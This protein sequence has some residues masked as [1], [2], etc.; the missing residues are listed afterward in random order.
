MFE[1]NMGLWIA[2]L[3]A[4]VTLLSTLAA[5][6]KKW[7]GWAEKG[8]QIAVKIPLIAVLLVELKEALGKFVDLE[9]GE[10][11]DPRTITKAQMTAILKECYDVYT[12]MDKLIKDP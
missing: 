12:A 7:R 6:S 10:P 8:K 3:T 5:S 1:N 11:I 9:T 4:I 2:L